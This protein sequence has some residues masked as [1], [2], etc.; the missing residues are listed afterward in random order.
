MKAALTYTFLVAVAIF[1][2]GSG[3]ASAAIITQYTFTGDTYSATTVASN[4]SATDY[5]TSAANKAFDS[6]EGNPSPSITSDGYNVAGKY[7]FFSLTVDGGYELELENLTFDYR[8]DTGGG[9]APDYDVSYSTD[10]FATVDISIGSGTV[11]RHNTNW[12]TGVA[13]S[14][15]LP[16]SGLTGTV[17]FRLTVS[18]APSMDKKWLHDNVTVNGSVIPEPATLAVLLI[19]SLALL[20]KRKA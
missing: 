10:A 14:D 11:S 9:G 16:T 17:S 12:T 20:R 2:V 15:T 8:F 18:N 1:L 19:G 7:Y 5:D 6:G 3:T 4:V 13:A